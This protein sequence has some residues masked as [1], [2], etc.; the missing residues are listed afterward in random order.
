[1]KYY[2]EVL[3][4]LFNSEKELVT[5]E[6]AAKIMAEER[7]KA[8]EQAEAEKKAAI[9]KAEAEKKAKAEVRKQR[10]AE[11]ENALKE[12]N[13]AQQNYQKLLEKFCQDYGAFHFSSNNW[14]DLPRIFPFLF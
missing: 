1:M 13:K 6:K 14:E 10:A 9:A 3:S 11:V 2:S 7:A 4:R 12:V 8:R 5:A